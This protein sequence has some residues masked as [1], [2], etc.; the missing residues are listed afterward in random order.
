ME[1]YTYLIDQLLISVITMM[2]IIYLSLLLA[3]T[4]LSF[5][6]LNFSDQINFTFFL[7]FVYVLYIHTANIEMIYFI[8][9]FK[10]TLS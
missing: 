1:K 8:L 4:Y 10:K 5:S 2:M 6:H 7:M 9:N 3:I